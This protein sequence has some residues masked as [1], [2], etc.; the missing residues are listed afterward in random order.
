MV[1]KSCEALSD[2]SVDTL[3]EQI[4]VSRL[5]KKCGPVP[6]VPL[7]LRFGR[8]QDDGQVSECCLAAHT[9]AQLGTVHFGHP[10]VC[11]DETRKDMH[12]FV[13]RFA[14]TLRKHGVTAVCF[15]GQ[16][17]RP[18]IFRVVVDKKDC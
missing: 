1:L 3:Y 17:Q 5:A 11:H 13:Q 15:Q 7:R 16:L 6:G 10:E 4:E 2:K 12:E 14:S 9:A 18:E 8:Q